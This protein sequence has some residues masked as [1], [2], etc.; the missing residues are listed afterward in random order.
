[1]TTIVTRTKRKIKI[2]YNGTVQG[3]KIYKSLKAQLEDNDD[4]QK[5]RITVDKCEDNDETYICV[6]VFDNAKKIPELTV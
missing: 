4:F 5:G 1:M 6:C 3:N 2:Y